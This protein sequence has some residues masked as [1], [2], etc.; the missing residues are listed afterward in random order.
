MK[1]LQPLGWEGILEARLRDQVKEGVTPTSWSKEE[2]LRPE[3]A[4]W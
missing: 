2:P 1:T 4:M 3:P